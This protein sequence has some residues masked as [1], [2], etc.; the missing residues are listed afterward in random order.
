IV[1]SLLGCHYYT[2]LFEKRNTSKYP[3]EVVVL[4]RAD[5]ARNLSALAA[6]EARSTSAE[7]PLWETPPLGREGKRGRR[8]E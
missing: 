7:N 2:M 8:C 5:I 1:A 4:Q 3:P 6:T